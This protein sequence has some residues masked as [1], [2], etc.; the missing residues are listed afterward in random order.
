M[1][2]MGMYEILLIL[3][4][5]GGGVGGLPMQP[6]EAP[7]DNVWQATSAILPGAHM[8]LHG[9]LEHAWDQLEGLM[10]E[11]TGLRLVK[12]S[13]A[14]VQGLA[15]AR[16]GIA[17]TA[18][19]G[20]AEIGL[21][22][23]KDLG[24]VTASTRSDGP[25]RIQILV[26]ARGHFGSD[27]IAAAILGIAPQTEVYKGVTLY[28]LPEGE[29]PAHV[30]CLPD[31][32]TA[33]LGPLDVVKRIL[34]GEP[35]TE[36]GGAADIVA[37]AIRRRA[38]LAL[39]WGGAAV[40]RPGSFL[41]VSP[42]AWMVDELF[43][44]R[45]LRHA[46]A[47]LQGLRSMVHVTVFGRGTLTFD[48]TSDRTMTLVAHL[49]YAASR[50]NAATDPLMDAL[51]HVAAAVGPLLPAD[52][53]GTEVVAALTDEPGLREAVEWLRL[54]L[55]AGTGGVVVDPAARRVTLEVDSPLGLTSM[56]MPLGSGMGWLLLAGRGE[57]VLMQEA[58]PSEATPDTEGP[59]DRMKDASGPN[60]RGGMKLA[61]PDEG[62][63]M[64]VGAEA[65]LDS[66]GVPTGLPSDT[67]EPN[68]RD[69][70][71]GG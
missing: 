11:V 17:Q 8:A 12:A 33:L 48:M 32:T 40:D 7:R 55:F 2:G 31:E 71:P 61:E 15:M 16:A 38:A 44:E 3:G 22:F 23:R 46:A 19:M 35:L 56:L 63:G 68:R 1:I 34:D 21:D 13:P 26:R 39:L 54:R 45:E 9:N 70:D 10:D 4:L 24:S 37:A 29:I 18:A 64:D 52:E 66:T 14:A 30:I 53:V 69:L 6:L 20:Q 41:Y 51:F 43:K 50:I 25:D 59:D 36:A 67:A 49:A 5:L 60:F 58:I 47:A 65:P 57:E 28:R 42:P 62:P 27:R